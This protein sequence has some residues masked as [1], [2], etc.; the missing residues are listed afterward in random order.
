MVGFECQPPASSADAAGSDARLCS[1]ADTVLKRS[2]LSQQAGDSKCQ[3][4]VLEPKLGVQT[5]PHGSFQRARVARDPCIQQ[6]LLLEVWPR[7]EE[8]LFEKQG[9]CFK[10]HMQAPDVF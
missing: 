3:A 7:V 4:V 6:K 5:P 9:A 2:L 1:D 10:I 8:S